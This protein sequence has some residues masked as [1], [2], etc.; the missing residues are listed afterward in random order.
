MLTEMLVLQLGC[1]FS[2]ENL[3]SAASAAAAESNQ[4]SQG[5]ETRGAVR[6]RG[7]EDHRQH[8][9]GHRPPPFHLRCH[10]CPA[11]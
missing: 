3:A 8:R 2:G 6:H 1:D 10:R 7:C 11:L 9:P 5:T 4:P